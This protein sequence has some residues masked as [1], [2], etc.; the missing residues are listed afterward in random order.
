MIFMIFMKLNLNRLIATERRKIHTAKFLGS[1]IL[2]LVKRPQS[3]V[4]EN[5]GP[6]P[7]SSIYQL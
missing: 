5:L 4:A 6:S 1:E 2:I 7:K 3:V